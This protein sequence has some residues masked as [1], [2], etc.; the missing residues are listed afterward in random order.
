MEQFNI[1]TLLAKRGWLILLITATVFAAS[2]AATARK[3]DS[4]FAS[5]AITV[6]P[7]RT[8]PDTTQL[9]IQADPVRD[10]QLLVATTSA[11]ITDPGSVQRVLQ[12][13]NATIPNGSLK[14]LS[15]YFQVVPGTEG[16]ATYQV[17]YSGISPEEV[18]RITAELQSSLR[19]MESAYNQR[20]GNALKLHL[21]FGEVVLTSRDSVLP[22]TPVIGL[23]AGFLFA[24]FLT[25]FL[26]RKEK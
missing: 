6:T 11:W 9:I 20:E 25:A 15:R 14:G 10:T 3:P 17:Q 18:R 24:L 2:W 19:Q 22:L 21:T 23:L 4:T 8:Y 26:E 12:G 16:S 13:A 7:Q 5:L 1:L